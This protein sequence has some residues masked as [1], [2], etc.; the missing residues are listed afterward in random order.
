ASAS[1]LEGVRSH[2]KCCRLNFREVLT[3]ASDANGSQSPIVI[4]LRA[5]FVLYRSFYRIDVISHGGEIL[6]INFLPSDIHNRS[7]PF[8]LFDVVLDSFHQRGE[9]RIKVLIIKFQTQKFHEHLVNFQIA[10]V[11]LRRPDREF[12]PSIRDKTPSLLLRHEQIALSQSPETH[13]P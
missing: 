2:F 7:F 9:L 3:Q 11:A 5:H 8:L 13:A 12:P 10:P 6:V 4:S 1:S